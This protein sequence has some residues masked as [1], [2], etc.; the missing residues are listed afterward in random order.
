MD[1]VEH[2]VTPNIPNGRDVPVTPM[3]VRGHPD[4]GSDQP[5]GASARMMSTG[6]WEDGA[7]DAITGVL[8][9]AST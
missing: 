3:R 4:R 9:P 2:C 7:M 1:R 6:A 5:L 8:T